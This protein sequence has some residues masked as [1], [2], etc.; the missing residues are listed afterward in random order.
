[1]LRVLL[2]M[3]CEPRYGANLVK[4]LGLLLTLADADLAHWWPDSRIITRA[5]RMDRGAWW[6]ILRDGVSV[7]EEVPIPFLVGHSAQG[8]FLISEIDTAGK[9]FTRW[10]IA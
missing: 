9:V 4:A 1:M 5:G 10:D 6:A 7:P 2:A 8:G 3:R